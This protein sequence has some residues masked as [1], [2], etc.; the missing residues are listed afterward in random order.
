MIAIR[1]DDHQILAFV[2]AHLKHLKVVLARRL[3]IGDW[4]SKLY[5]IL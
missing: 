5:L 3:R 2:Q 4:D 1:A